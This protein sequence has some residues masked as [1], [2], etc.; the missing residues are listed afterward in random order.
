MLII[1]RRVTEEIRVGDSITI[2]IL[3]IQGNQVRIGIEAPRN[4]S[5]D[6]EEVY[7]KKRQRQQQTVSPRTSPP[8]GEQL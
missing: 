1:T 8:D 4:L 7:Q 3:G 2:A 5:I 6:R